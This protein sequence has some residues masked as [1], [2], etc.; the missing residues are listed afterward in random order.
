[1]SVFKFPGHFCN[2]LQSLVL[3]F[4]WGEDDGTK[5]IPWI[6]WKRLCSKKADGGP[7]FKDFGGFNAALLGKQSWRLLTNQT[8]LWARFMRGKYFHDKTFL[9]ADLGRNPSYAWRGVWGSIKA[10]KLGI[11]RRI[12]DGL[13]TQAWR[14]PW[15]QVLR[16]G[17]C[18]H[19]GVTTTR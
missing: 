6:A 12:G 1:M 7:G 16:P 9:E 13:S 17:A 18:S 19:P 4:Q 15:I 10:I 3:N 11:R 2:E 14:D 5:K 8:R